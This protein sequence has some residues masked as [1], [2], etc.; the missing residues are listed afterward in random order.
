[1][2][3]SPDTR[4]ACRVRAATQRPR[5]SP[6][7]TPRRR[8]RSET[9]RRAYRDL[10]QELFLKRT[11]RRRFAVTRVQEIFTG[12]REF[13]RPITPPSQ[14]NGQLRISPHVRLRQRA[15]E[16]EYRVNLAARRQIE[17]RT[18]EDLIGRIVM[19]AA[20]LAGIAAHRRHMEILRE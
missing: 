12:G 20:S 1:M 2:P 14:P 17:I 11:R 18:E 9:P 3:L 16:S 4:A 6:R 7:R 13:H 15:D 10:S 8:E 19:L 5:E